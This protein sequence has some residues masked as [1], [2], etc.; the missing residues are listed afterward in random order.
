[1]I[2][3]LITLIEVTDKLLSYIEKKVLQLNKV[4]L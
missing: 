3:T 2:E 4:V 1:M